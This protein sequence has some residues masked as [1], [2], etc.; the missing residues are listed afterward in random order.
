MTTEEKAAAFEVLQHV[1][2][3]QHFLNVIVHEL[4]K[5]G[6]DHD[7]SKLESPELETLT[8]FNP[9]T[10]YGSTE[11]EA[12]RKSI[13]SALDHHYARNRHHP[14]HYPNG[15]ADMDLVDIVEMFCDWKAATERYYNGNLLKS[16]EVNADRFGLPLMMVKVFENTAKLLDAAA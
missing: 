12:E 9:E 4:L 8:K 5:R 13:Q 2:R 11:D 1:L 10:R 16:V 3:V 14:Q 15:V 6:E 7:K